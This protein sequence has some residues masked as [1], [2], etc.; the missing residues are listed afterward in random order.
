MSVKR[1]TGALIF[2]LFCAGLAHAECQLT[3]SRPALNYGKV[4]EKDFS[5]QHKRWKT[6]HEREVRITA[7][8]DA[9]TKMAIFGQGGANDDG[10]RMASDSLMLVKASDA[11]LDGKPVLLGK[12]HSH[13]AFVP[14]GSG[15]DKK[16]WRDNEGLL[17]MSGAGVAE[18]KEFSMTL[19]ILPALSARDTQVTDKTTLESNLHFTVETQ[20]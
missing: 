16:L 19:T 11:S 1:L 12:T 4:H 6:L 18:G 9:P 3:L 5:G 20:Q 10:F 8:C 13:S 15:S 2:G 7:L 14:E 17:P